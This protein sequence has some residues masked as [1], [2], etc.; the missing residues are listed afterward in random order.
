MTVLRTWQLV[1]EEKLITSALRHFRRFRG[2]SY[3]ANPSIS[4][5]SEQ[6]CLFVCNPSGHKF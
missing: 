5:N 1:L 2:F 4:N 3:K 6:V